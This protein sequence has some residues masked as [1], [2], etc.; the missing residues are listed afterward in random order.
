[1]QNRTTAELHGHGPPRDK[2]HSVAGSGQARRQR[3]TDKTRPADEQYRRFHLRLY[4]T[5][6]R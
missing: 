2:V 5:T 6:V 4:L 1:M 3:L